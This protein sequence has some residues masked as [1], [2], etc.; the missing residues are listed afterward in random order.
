M[1]ERPENYAGWCRETHRRLRLALDLSPWLPGVIELELT[2]HVIQIVGQAI[3]I[4]QGIHCFL[5]APG[6]LGGHGCEMR[7]AGSEISPEV[8]VCSVE[9][10][11]GDCL[12]MLQS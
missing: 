7:S 6:A 5:G 4:L 1:P 3:E 10:E 12:G 2:D 11:I 9:V 8:E